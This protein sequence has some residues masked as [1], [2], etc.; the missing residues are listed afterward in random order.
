MDADNENLGPTSS[1][2]VI[3]PFRPVPQV[4]MDHILQ[5]V[6]KHDQNNDTRSY[7]GQHRKKKDFQTRLD[8]G[9]NTS[10]VCSRLK[11]MDHTNLA[12]PDL[13]VRVASNE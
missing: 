4:I 11:Y 13:S 5:D 7:E 10:T 9:R 8:D 1:D 3:A 6:T 12:Y 2:L